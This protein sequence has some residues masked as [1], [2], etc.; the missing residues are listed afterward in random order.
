MKLRPVC[1]TER[2]LRAGNCPV[3]SADPAGEGREPS[4][5]FSRSDR[6]R[7]AFK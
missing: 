2:K 7:E 1:G 3:I 6:I 4:D 5:R